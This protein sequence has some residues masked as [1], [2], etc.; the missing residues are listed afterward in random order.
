MS[1]TLT[2]EFSSSHQIAGL[3]ALGGPAETNSVIRLATIWHYLDP[4]C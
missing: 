4:L 2:G 3:M 1:I